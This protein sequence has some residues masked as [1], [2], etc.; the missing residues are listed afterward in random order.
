MTMEGDPIPL[1][2][3]W[4][5]Q[6]LGLLRIVTALLFLE[7]GTSK[8][9]YFPE[10]AGSGPS[11]WSLLWVAGWMEL[12]GSAMLLLG[13]FT[14]PVALLLAGEMAV[15][16]WTVHAPKS[17]FPVLNQGESAILFCFI[18]LLFA[19]TGAGEWSVDSLLGRRP[20]IEGYQP[21]GI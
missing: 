18:F 16:Y 6:A 4:V 19:A 1:D 11:D 14:R 9:L 13:L 2:G 10:T 8:I 7:H 12:L 20:R 5:P 3:R 21:P 17:V 15:A